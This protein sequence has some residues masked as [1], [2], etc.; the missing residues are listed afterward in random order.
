MNPK[1]PA[2][3]NGRRSA[4]LPGMA[5]PQKPTIHEAVLLRCFAFHLEGSDI[6]GRRQA[7]QRHVDDRGD[8]TRRGR[9]GGAGEALPLGPTG[10]V[11]VYVGVHQAG[12]QHLVGGQRHDAIRGEVYP[13]IRDRGDAAVPDG[14]GAGTLAPAGHR[15][16]SV[17]DEVEMLGHDDPARCSLAIRPASCSSSGA[18]FVIDRCTSGSRSLRL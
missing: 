16:R 15:P 18:A 5:P 4:T 2:S 14:D 13:E 11:D 8:A 10:V 1:T 3:C 6:D 12:E 9:S 17:Q 7:V